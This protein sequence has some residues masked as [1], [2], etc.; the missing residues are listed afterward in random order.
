[1]S[2]DASVNVPNNVKDHA[3]KMIDSAETTGDKIAAYEQAHQY[4]SKYVAKQASASS[5]NL[6]IVPDG[7]DELGKDMQYAHDTKGN[8]YLD[9]GNGWERTTKKLMPGSVYRDKQKTLEDKLTTMIHGKMVRDNPN[10]KAPESNTKALARD[11]A[12]GFTSLR[13]DIGSLNDDQLV[14][15]AENTLEKAGPAHKLTKAGL[16]AAV[17]G[18]GLLTT[19]E[20]VKDKY[21]TSFEGKKRVDPP[22]E[23]LAEYGS[24]IKNL[25][26]QNKMTIE[27][28]VPIVEARWE[29]FKAA[30]PAKA[31]S[32]EQVPAMDTTG[33]RTIPPII[34]WLKNGG[35]EK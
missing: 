16:R 4:L 1:M 32:M 9:S 29:K 23:A 33:N 14:E 18:N 3:Q 30:N 11:V 22:V 35:T 13:S 6:T 12:T 27:E 25:A 34:T 8:M 26:K 20:T 7:R 21:Y 28:T 15:V 17:L 5:G 19:R 24:A 2:L 10:D 31:K